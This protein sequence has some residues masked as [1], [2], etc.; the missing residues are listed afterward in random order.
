MNEERSER[1]F[2]IMKQVILDN[3]LSSTESLGERELARGLRFFYSC[4][5][6]GEKFAGRSLRCHTLYERFARFHKEQRRKETTELAASES[7][8]IEQFRSMEEFRSIRA[9]SAPT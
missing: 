5:I 2:L 7:D 8:L 3:Q 6:V 4:V 1:F 9:P